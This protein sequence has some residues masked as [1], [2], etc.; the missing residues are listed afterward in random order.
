[1]GVASG[2]AQPEAQRATRP[3]PLTTYPPTVSICCPSLTADVP[4]YPLYM[5]RLTAAAAPTVSICCPS[6]T[7]T[8]AQVTCMSCFTDRLV[9][10]PPP[11]PAA[12]PPAAAAAEWIC[13]CG[14]TNP[15]EYVVCMGCFA[16]KPRSTQQQT[17]GWHC[18]SCG[19]ANM[20]GSEA[21]ESASL[22]PVA[23]ESEN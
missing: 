13:A 21:C 20:A 6:L 11:P 1:M 19:F 4:F 22:V 5:L 3:T 10:R 8:A 9:P 18:A 16:D 15:T 23:S 14:Q 2:L 12:A 7:V 17:A